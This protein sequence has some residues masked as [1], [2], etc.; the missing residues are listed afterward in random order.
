M[1]ISDCHHCKD[2]LFIS[3]VESIFEKFD[4]HK[5]ASLLYFT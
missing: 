4:K 1:L 5:K 3:F 2:I